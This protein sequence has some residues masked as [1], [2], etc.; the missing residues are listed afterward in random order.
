[1]WTDAALFFE[2][3][4]KTLL[5][6]GINIYLDTR[7]GLPAPDKK[8]IGLFDVWLSCAADARA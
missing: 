4:K 1:M 2:K 6:T 3:D 5:N 7:T 8:R